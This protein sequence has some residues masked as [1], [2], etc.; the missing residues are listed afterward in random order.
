MAH[1]QDKIININNMIIAYA[2][3]L[4]PKIK[5]SNVSTFTC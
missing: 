5:L 4:N 1:L 3:Q 2:K